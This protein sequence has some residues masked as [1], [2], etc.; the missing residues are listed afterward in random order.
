MGQKEIRLNQKQPKHPYL[1][2]LAITF[3]AIPVFADPNGVNIPAQEDISI[4]SA[5][6]SDEGVK[7]NRPVDLSVAQDSLLGVVGDAKLLFGF[8]T[9][10][11]AAV[12]LAAGPKVFRGN[13]TYAFALNDKNR[14]K[15][16]GEYLDEDLDFDFYT[17]ETR[18]WVDQVAVGAAYQYWL[19]GDTFKDV[20]IGSHYSHAGS[21]DLSDKVINLG[22]GITL[23]DQRRIAGGTDWNG[24]VETGI[25]LWRHGL[26]TAGADYDE[27]RYDTKYEIH[28]EGGNE[29]G[30][31][32]HL[33]L[34]QLL[35]PSTQLELKSSVTQLA[36]T[37]SGGLNWIWTARSG[38]ALRAGFESGYT[39]D[40][41]TGRNFWINGISLNIVWD[42]ARDK[43]SVATY[44][45]PDVAAED[46]LTWAATPAVR[47]PDVLAITDERITKTGEVI[48]DFVSVTAACPESKA[49]QYDL[50][51]KT[52]SAPGGWVQS[53][54][55]SNLL[56]QGNNKKSFNSANI[57]GS[58]AGGTGAAECLYDIDINEL[59][60]VNSTYSFVQAK[61]GTW[62]NNTPSGFWPESEPLPAASCL[63]GAADCTF[64]T[65]DPKTM[66]TPKAKGDENLQVERVQPTK[67]RAE[68]RQE[69]G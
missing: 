26:V 17:G 44:S 29:Q 25:H 42:Q 12:E 67:R 21:K 38:T 8:N 2:F 11:A 55:S 47:M 13:G 7:D 9:E 37:Y 30:F 59:I 58:Q 4:F 27:V 56:S 39:E 64:K 61:D 3:F 24:T 52:Y 16:T 35:A 40:H 53:Y 43:K 23:L 69:H 54:P 15:I 65:L 20:Q 45:D 1:S 57:A 18:Q 6:N 48:P 62:V 49:L 31:G 51:T 10:N 14:I 19:G 50:S 32:G 66:A 63:T 36:D 34:Q 60:L 68:L 46:L 5:D 33:N 28:D 22:N 41:A